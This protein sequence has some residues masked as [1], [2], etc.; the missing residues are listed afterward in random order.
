MSRAKHRRE[1]VKRT[2]TNR[3]SNDSHLQYVSIFF[4]VEVQVETHGQTRSGWMDDENIYRYLCLKG[5]KHDRILLQKT[6]Q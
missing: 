3:V 6:L 1:R 2:L 4:F 5:A